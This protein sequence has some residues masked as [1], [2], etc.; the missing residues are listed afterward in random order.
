MVYNPEIST[1]FSITLPITTISLND[2]VVHLDEPLLL[3]IDVLDNNGPLYLAYNDTID[4]CKSSRSLVRAV[5]EMIDEYRRAWETYVE[6]D[7]CSLGPEALW[8]RKRL[9]EME[10]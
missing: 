9:E 1:V 2:R 7:A 4:A 8:F 3:T 5:N 6:C 10:K